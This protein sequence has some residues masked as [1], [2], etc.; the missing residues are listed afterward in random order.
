MIDWDK[1]KASVI[2]IG[3]LRPVQQFEHVS[4]NKSMI[5]ISNAI[6]NGLKSS[7]KNKHLTH[8]FYKLELNVAQKTESL[9]TKKAIDPVILIVDLLNLNQDLI[10]RYFKINWNHVE[11]FTNLSV[12]DK[13]V[14]IEHSRNGSE[15]CDAFCEILDKEIS[16]IRE[17]FEWQAWIRD[18][19]SR[20]LKKNKKNL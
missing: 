18:N 5:K 7:R 3:A 9:I 17:I 14:P 12:F 1:I 19:N 15:Y 2:C 6:N 20:F 10:D 13:T 11:K 8:L 16:D 4:R